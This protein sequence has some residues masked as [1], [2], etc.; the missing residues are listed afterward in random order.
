M[1]TTSYDD[2]ALRRMMLMR[3]SGTIRNCGDP[4]RV[5]EKLIANLRRRG[6]PTVSRDH[7]ERVA[8]TLT[9]DERVAPLGTYP[10]PAVKQHPCRACHRVVP[11][12]ECETGDPGCMHC[13]ACGFGDGP[14]AEL[15]DDDDVAPYLE[16][17]GFAVTCTGGGCMAYLRVSHDGVHTLITHDV[18]LGLPERLSDPIM[19]GRYHGCDYGTPIDDP[20]SFESA[21]DYLAGRTP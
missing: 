13:D 5:A 21:K 10:A 17:A 14:G 3:L 16:R 18:D 15:A 2:S 11:H 12:H 19:V 9:F 1:S 8:D 20:E 6:E 4:R 7:A